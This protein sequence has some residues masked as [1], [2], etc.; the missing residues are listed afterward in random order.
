[1]TAEATRRRCERPTDDTADPTEGEDR[2]VEDAAQ[3]VR[4]PGVH[5]GF[6]HADAQH[7]GERVGLAKRGHHPRL[8]LDPAFPDAAFDH[9]RERLDV[10]Q[11][12]STPYRE[13]TT[14]R[15][16]SNG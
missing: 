4:Q 8:R 3:Q 16:G 5:H 13:D 12:R 14:G 6:D 7:P 11:I 10:G 15:V 9:P 1:M 2:A